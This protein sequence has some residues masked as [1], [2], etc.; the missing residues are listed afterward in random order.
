MTTT[1]VPL[2]RAGRALAAGLATALVVALG[3]CA[4]IPTSGPVTEGQATPEDPG[5]PFV[6]AASPIRDASPDQIVR[7]FLTAQAQGARSSF[8]VASEFLTDDAQAWSPL[9]Q[10]AVLE[11]VPQLEVDEATLEEGTTTVRATADVVGT[12]DE[13]GV[14]TEEVPGR[15]VEISY[16]LVRDADGQWRIATVEDGLSITATNFARTFKQVNLY[17]PTLDRTYLV[18]DARWF[19]SRNWQTLAVRETVRGPSEWLAGSVG[20]VVPE[21]TALSIDSVTPSDEGTVAV[22][23]N[24]AVTAASS[25]DRALLLAQLQAALGGR[26]EITIG[27][28]GTTLSADDVPAIGVATTPDDPVVLAG[29]QIM[30]LEGRTTQPVGSAAPLAGLQPTALAFRGR[31]SD[32]SYVVRDGAIRIVTAPTADAGPTTLLTG[33]NLL[34]PSIDRFQFLWSGPQVQPGSLQVVDLREGGSDTAVSEVAVPWL[35][36][37]T[38]MSVRVAPDGA[39]IAVV[40]D[41]GSGAQIHVAGIVRDEA[42]RPTQLSD[43][44]RVGQPVLTATQVTWVDRVLLGVLGR[45]AGQAEPVVQRVPVGGPTV[46]ASPVEDAVSLASATGVGTMLVGTSDSSLYAAGTSTL[47]T[48]VAT[49]VRLPTYPG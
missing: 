17:F 22:P 18:P 27:V 5:Q 38:I 1:G 25:A 49:E 23:L 13:R 8:D 35:D 43:P 48:R 30:S 28:G 20:T 47:W 32:A 36:G 46:A 24:D 9:A 41:A 14:Y 11:D 34:A 33:A 37:R 4:S 31:S 12:V 19:P 44:I 42:G 7:G 40:S 10:V 2:R 15:T 21:G 39:R 45:A 6:S 16:G 26:V 29:D 3:A